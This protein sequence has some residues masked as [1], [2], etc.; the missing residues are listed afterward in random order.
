[1]IYIFVFYLLKYL[2]KLFQQ[3][4]PILPTGLGVDKYQECHF[5]RGHSFRVSILYP[6]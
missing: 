3:L 2:E 4:K 6:V 1:M 5:G